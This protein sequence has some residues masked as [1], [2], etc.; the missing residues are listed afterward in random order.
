MA[1]E[2]GIDACLL[3]LQACLVARDNYSNTAGKGVES[4]CALNIVDFN[5]MAR[6]HGSASNLPVTPKTSLS[7]RALREASRRR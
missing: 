2:T 6:V 1:A 5:A 7:E 3:R 4:S